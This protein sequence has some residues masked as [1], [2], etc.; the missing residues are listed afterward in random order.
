MKVVLIGSGNVATH[1][2]RA[3]RKAGVEIVCV[4]SRCLEHAQA[5]AHTLSAQATH[6]I[7]DLPDADVFIFSVSDNVL[8]HLVEQVGARFGHRTFIHTAGSISLDVFT[9]YAEHAS[10]M[11]PMQTFTKSVPVDFSH[12]PIYIEATNA[13]TE[14]LAWQ[15]ASRIS[16]NVK[17]LTS[18]ERK[19]LHLAAVFACNFANHCYTLAAEVMNRANLPFTDLLP[20][21]ETT[22]NKLHST[23]PLEG[24]T[25]PAVRNDTVV[26]DK[27]KALLADD[28]LKQEIYALMSQSILSKESKRI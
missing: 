5:L 13:E 24:Q 3:L 19:W 23:H 2:G 14:V 26:M 18:D 8:P 21:I 17:R 4:Y 27:Q 9:G 28:A 15:M 1:L 25:G 20:L 16:N 12:L 7:E 11:Y 10:V 22:T 6:R